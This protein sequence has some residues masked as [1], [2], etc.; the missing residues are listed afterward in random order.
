[1]NF[2]LILTLIRLVVAPLVL[3][4]LIVTLLPYNIFVI[5]FFLALLF[6]FFGITDFLDGYLARKYGQE[7]SLGRLLDPIADKFL[8]FSTLV[9][10]L[11]IGKIYFYWVI[12]IIGREFFVMGLREV[13][14]T[15]GF[16]IPV[17]MSGKIKTITQ[18]IFLTILILSPH[19]YFSNATFWRDCE[20]LLLAATLVTT[21]YSAFVYYQDF[22]LGNRL[23]DKF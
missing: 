18:F 2:P 5:N 7:T 23:L 1:M 10:L 15:H 17:G 16:T 22:T 12:I 6:V 3:P 4:I 21:L 8:V 9:S 14:L 13:A 20:L 19:L 11:A